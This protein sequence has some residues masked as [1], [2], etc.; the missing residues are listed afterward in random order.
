MMRARLRENTSKSTG[1]IFIGCCDGACTSVP[2]RPRV[3]SPHPGTFCRNGLRELAAQGEIRG[4]RLGSPTRP[5]AL[6]CE[7]W[8]RPCFDILKGYP[9]ICLLFAKRLRFFDW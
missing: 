9:V 4:T 7:F 1:P 8:E 3:W 2:Q 6:G 5:R